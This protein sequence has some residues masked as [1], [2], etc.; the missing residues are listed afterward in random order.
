MQPSFIEREFSQKD[1]SICVGMLADLNW[2][3]FILNNWDIFF[4]FTLILK[5]TSYDEP[6]PL[7]DGFYFGCRYEVK[8][9]LILC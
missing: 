8:V 1:G 9:R 2:F 4:L 3:F 6:L 7:D 5:A